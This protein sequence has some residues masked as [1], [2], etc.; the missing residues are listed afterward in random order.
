MLSLVAGA[1]DETRLDVDV[2]VVGASLAGSTVAT[3]LGRAGLRVALLDKHA[4][5]DAYKRL[6]GHY[7]QASTM[8]LLDRLGLAEE[9]ETAGGVR[10]GLDIWT[11]WG[12]I[13]SPE[14][15]ERRP[16]GYNLRRS[17]LDPLVRA[18]AIDTPGVSYLPGY[19]ATALLAG[20]DG[21][22]A[23]VRLEDRQ[24]D[25][26]AVRA[27]LVVGADGRN[28]TVAK[29]AGAREWRSANNRFCYSSHF[30]GVEL[31]PGSR[32]RLWLDDKEFAIAAP[33]A[34]G[35]TV[36][37]AFV[38]KPRLA[39]FRD[40][41]ERALL[42]FVARL[43]E[44]PNVERAERA[45][46][47]VAY[48]DY[49]LIMRNATP[50]P[51]VALVGDAAL[52][53]DPAMGIGCGW[54]FESASWLSDTVA[55]ALAGD[56]SLQ[57]ALRRYRRIHGQRL[58]PHHAQA[59]FDARAYGATPVHKLLFAAGARDQRTAALL[60]RVAERSAAPQRILAPPALVRAV[61]AGL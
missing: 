42:D 4:G 1:S 9:I 16:Y 33:Q 36:L 17:K 26:L 50:R 19:K 48:T 41:P 51:G 44:A 52:S 10:N 31:P 30:S 18:R 61:R 55:P 49:E 13:A 24:R 11:R 40:D 35:L 45:E 38:P 56:E 59:A 60:S 14:P 29:L 57:R 3:L 47:F 6:C 23:G 39:E 32:G 2:A 53:S 5:P 20:P 27:R 43:P 22:T 12:V 46:R 28:S 58:L 8:P 54:A 25:R 37:A 21:A 15:V 34:D 7:I